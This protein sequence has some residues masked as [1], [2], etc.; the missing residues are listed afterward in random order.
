[1]VSS[2]KQENVDAAVEQLRQQ[3][4]KAAGVVCH[5]SNSEDR[6]RLVEEMPED[7]WDKTFDINLKAPFL[8]CQEIVPHLEKRGAARV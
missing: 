6:H 1:M 8:L 4:L 2:R 5:V 7:T 3:N